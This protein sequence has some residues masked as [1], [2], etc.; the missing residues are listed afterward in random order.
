MK[1]L[2]NSTDQNIL[3]N[4]ET[5]F[6]TDL[7]WEEA[8]QDFEQD[9]LKSIINPTQNFETVRYI[10]S[11]YT[12]DNSIYQSDIWFYFY[13]YNNS[14]PKTHAGGLNYEYIGL[15]AQDNRLILKDDI[16]PSFFRL[17]F[18]KTPNDAYPDS[19]NRKLV[20]TKDLPI[21]FGE[22][23]FYT[24]VNDYIFVPVF[25]GSNYRNKGNMYLFWFQDDTVLDGTLLSGVTFYMTARFFNAIDGSIMSFTN[26]DKFLTDTID[27]ENDVYDKMIIDRTNYTYTIYSGNTSRVIGRSNTNTPIQFYASTVSNN[28]L[29]P[30]S[31]TPTPT[32]SITPSMTPSITVSP[33]I[34][35]SATPGLSPTLTPSITIS[36]TPSRTPTPTPSD[37]SYSI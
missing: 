35:I 23:I 22:K 30:V 5:N 8:M 29:F 31:P 25:T 7:G 1:I 10:H 37:F 33:T 34:N 15:T 24:P 18:Y 16:N 26:C 32:P 17:E 12:S 14:Y 9:T 19:N 2:Q 3:L 27:E 13:F 20:F 21:S 11:G 6:G 4:S 28:T 36:A